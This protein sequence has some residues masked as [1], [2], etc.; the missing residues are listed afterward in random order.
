MTTYASA[1]S[2]FLQRTPPSDVLLG[3]SDITESSSW[4]PTVIPQ[5][6]SYLPGHEHAAPLAADWR[7]A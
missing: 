7:D 5:T 6:P 4:I 2:K 1:L 3:N